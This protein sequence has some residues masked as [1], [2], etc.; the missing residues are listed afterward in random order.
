M[1]DSAADH[2]FDPRGASPA[3]MQAMSELARRAERELSEFAGMRLGD[4]FR[5]AQKS[6]GDELPEFWTVWN[7]WNSLPDDP[8]PWGDL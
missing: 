3:L 5:L 2:E 4:A 8:A 1:D 6:Y 7:S